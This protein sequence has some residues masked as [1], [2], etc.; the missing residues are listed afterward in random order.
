MKRPITLLILVISLTLTACVP[1]ACAPPPLQ[2]FE[3]EFTGLFDTLTLIIGYAE[4]K[5]D[6][7]L[8][9]Q[10]L[11][12]DLE[13]YHQ[14]Y[15]I[16]QR[17]PGIT[18][19]RDVNQAAGQGPVEVDQKIIDL[20]LFAQTYAPQTGD[21]VNIAL[22]PVLSLWHEAREAGN[23]DPSAARLPDPSDLEAAS[24]HTNAQDLIIDPVKKTV[25]I[26]DPLLSLDVGAIAKGYAVE[27]A[28]RAA[29]DRGVTHML[30]SVGGNVRAIGG[31]GNGDPWKV[32]VDQPDKAKEGYLAVLKID[33]LSLVT[34]GVTERFYIVDGQSYHHIIDPDTLFPENRY[35]SVSVI[36]PDSGL[37]DLLS[38]SLFNLDLE[39][40]LAL[41]ESLAD[42]E[43][44]WCLAD[45]SLARSSGFSDYECD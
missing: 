20:L 2:R 15:D 12:D 9:V 42:T 24:L 27:A 35:Q 31:R 19:L 17:Y 4:K 36:N 13:S 11:M 40:G 30:I 32:G 21:R 26:R 18:N 6:F 34:S 39:Q 41:V 5:A 29:Q 10:A 43:A 37:A 25:E 1:L 14:L 33:N 38:T 16:Y 22:G 23:L 44:L 28:A 3:S 7:D 8:Q 45:G